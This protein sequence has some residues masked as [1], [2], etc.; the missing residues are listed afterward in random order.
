VDQGAQGN[1]PTPWKT[2]WLPSK[3][4]AGYSAV[5]QNSNQPTYYAV[6]VQG[7]KNGTD[8]LYDVRV[9]RQ[10]VFP[11]AD[12]THVS[13]GAME[14]LKKVFYTLNDALESMERFLQPLIVPANQFLVTGHSL[15]GATSGLLASWIAYH[16][17]L[18]KSVT[19]FPANVSAITFA[20]PAIG[21]SNFADF[22]NRQ[23]GY[24][25][26]CNTNDAVPHAWCLEGQ[27][28]IP[29]LYKLFPSPGPSPMP[30]D[31]KLIVE[32][33]VA[34]M[35]KN[36]VSYQQ[37][38]VSTFTFPTTSASWMDELGYQHNYAYEQHFGT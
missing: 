5:L 25:A 8:V 14:D 19:V 34:Q 35:K 18:Q 12:G 27:F 21:D 38:N 26:N 32:S 3:P 13:V 36:G 2:V 28:S 33:I 24:S 31:D 23:S 30:P 11:F 16:L 6:A 22:L 29:N 4:G 15:G 9:E 1:P 37:T 20:A 7:T 17:N 10:V